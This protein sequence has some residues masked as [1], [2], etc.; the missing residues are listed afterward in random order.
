MENRIT[1]SKPGPVGAPQQ[2]LDGHH[3][4]LMGHASGSRPRS[5]V[6]VWYHGP[7]GDW[8]VLPRQ[9][10]AAGGSWFAARSTATSRVMRD[11]GEE[12][13]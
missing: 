10:R 4:H 3:V 11:R 9:W 7:A 5:V 13:R 8:G 1:C 12:T 2:L 6:L